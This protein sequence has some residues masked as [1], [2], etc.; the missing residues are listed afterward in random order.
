MSLDKRC[1]QNDL[2]PGVKVKCL[3]HVAD[4]YEK[5]ATI[6]SVE[7]NGSFFTVKWDD[8]KEIVSDWRFPSSFALID[9]PEAT[10]PP[11]T[12]S[13]STSTDPEEDRLWKMMRPYIPAGEC[14]CGGPKDL[15]PYHKDQP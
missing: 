8:G 12:V 7:P 11:Q 2:K 4:R 15:C 1:T 10:S 13:S 6:V 9:S 3:Y 14:V 5:T